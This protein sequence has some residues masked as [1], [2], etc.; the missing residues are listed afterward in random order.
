[1]LAD[2]LSFINWYLAIALAGWISLPLAFKFFRFLPDRGYA[3][4][5]PLG[6]LTTGYIFWLLG[7]LGFLQND[8]GGILLAALLTGS[9]GMAW[10]RLP[11]FASLRGWI[12]AQRR[13]VL[14]VEL[15][16]LFAFAGW[17]LIRAY[18]PEILGTEKPME[19]MFLNSILR[20][21]SFPPLDAWLSGHAISYY[22]FGYVL[23]AALASVTQTA[24][25]VAFN[26]GLAMLFALTATASF[27]LV[28]NLI[29][30]VK[31]E[32]ASAIRKPALPLYSA[33]WPALLGPLLVLLIGNFYGALELAHN[34][35][36]LVNLEVPAVWYGFGQIEDPRQARSLADFDRPPGIR[37]GLINFWE[38]LDLK[39][40]DPSPPPRL[41]GFR[42]EL[43]KWFFAARVV[44]DRNLAGIET[45]AIDENPAFSFLLGDMH[46]HVLALPFV[47]LALALAL[48]WLLWMRETAGAQG[49]HSDVPWA[50]F[51]RLL[52]SGVIL[53]SLAFLNTWDFPI[54]LFLVALALTIGLGLG[55][56]WE[57]ILKNWRYLGLFSI[58]LALLGFLLY[59]PFYLTFQSQAGGI[60]PNLIY[61]TRFQQ[62]VVMFGPVL[63]GA[64]LFAGWAAFRWQNVLNWQ[65]AWWAGGGLVA[66]LVLLLI[67]FTSFAARSTTLMAYADQAVYPLNRSEAFTLLLQR[68][69][70]DSLATL[71]PAALIG[72]AAGLMVGAL[73]CVK[74]HLT[75]FPTETFPGDPRSPA[76]LMA[77]A[78]LLTG[79]LL[80]IGPEFLYLRDNFGTRMNTIF[81]FYF[82]IWVLWALVSAFGIWYIG[83]Q[84]RRWVRYL[85]VGLLSMVILLGG[86]YLPGSLYSK[87]G[88]F[89]SPPTLDG[90]A[91]FARSFPNDWAAIQW[92]NQN[93]SGTPVILEGSRG[94]YW[95]EGHSSR[96][97]M[98]TGLPT[99]MGW[100]NHQRQWRGDYFAQ[101]AGRVEDIHQIYQ[102]RDWNATQAILAE[103]NIEYVIVSTL[104]LD[105]Y[106]PVNLQKFDNYMEPVFQSGDVIIYRK[107]G[108]TP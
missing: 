68:R 89:A 2:L 59:L 21:P 30:L 81:K 57:A 7:S 99:L 95:S 100:E 28:L 15:L 73:R 17:A 48:E 82:Q 27:G 38:W 58:T 66:G 56:G 69:L 18:N 8:T 5:K 93:V 76:V 31:G 49:I 37:A 51:T 64:T 87:T 50:P 85:V 16:F 67:L 22:Y 26:L 65:A 54:Y 101:V 84:A 94:A 41:D 20:S 39:Q 9:L 13:Y 40:L 29:A 6:L 103:Y 4:T 70:V 75:G 104:E 78:M 102:L 105:W 45:E 14:A 92:L 62:T 3:F 83:Q 52:L 42:W 97:S 61:P 80:L 98:A 46:P 1:M 63:A 35:R 79:A 90:M 60:L 53:G 36:L 88:G 25:G 74:I 10:L 108:L 71:Y 33:F 24:P 55:L 12:A 44:H 23:V 72:L 107:R 77:L 11:G 19:F 47:I 106:R 32:Q 86:V 34:N 96:I 43:G 91:Y